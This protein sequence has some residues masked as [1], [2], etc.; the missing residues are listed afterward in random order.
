MGFAR[1]V[2]VDA[3]YQYGVAPLRICGDRGQRWPF[4]PIR[5]LPHLTDNRRI[6]RVTRYNSGPNDPNEHP[7]EIEILTLVL[8]ADANPNE[9]PN[10]RAPD[11]KSALSIAN[12][13]KEHQNSARD[14]LSLGMYLSARSRRRRRMPQVSLSGETNAQR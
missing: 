3:R 4:T 14:P 8:R 9:D 7:S 13:Y 2:R 12:E 6:S 5:S 1:E 11:G 10:Y